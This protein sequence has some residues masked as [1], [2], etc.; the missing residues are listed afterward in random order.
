MTPRRLIYCMDGTWQSQDQ[1]HPTNVA[2]L[3]RMIEISDRQIVRYDAGVGTGF[4]RIAGGLFGSGIV[5]NIV[6]GYDWIRNRYQPGDRIILVGFS[7][8]ASS[9]RE[10]AAML[11]KLG[12]WG[13]ESLSG[14][15]CWDMYRDMRDDERSPTPCPVQAVAVWDTVGARGVPTGNGRWALAPQFDDCDLGHHVQHGYHALAYHERRKAFAPALWTNEKTH[16]GMILQEWFPGWH[17]D[18]GG[19]A[20][21][22]GLSD[23]AISWMIANLVSF[24]GLIMRPGYS[25]LIRPNANAPMHPPGFFTRLYGMADRVIPPD[26]VLN[27]S[28][29]KDA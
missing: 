22:T 18:V 23:I 8:G 5:Q 7:R 13:V 12:I 21:G 17:S 26:A 16:P 4:P 3:A 11:G 2:K 10:L 9:A 15:E 27:P 29:N 20:P 1:R 14:R 19:G 25:D 28:L 24:D 6:E